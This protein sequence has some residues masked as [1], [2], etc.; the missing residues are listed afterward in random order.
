MMNKHAIKITKI[1]KKFIKS[2]GQVDY[3]RFLKYYLWMLN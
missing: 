2:E 3:L 1:E